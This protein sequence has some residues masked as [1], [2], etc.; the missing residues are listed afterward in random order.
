MGAY[1]QMQQIIRWA[2]VIMLASLLAGCAFMNREN[3][4]LMNQVEDN[5]WPEDTA[6]Q[7]LVFPVVF[8]I[9]FAALLVDVVVVH[10]STV[11]GDAWADTEDLLWRGM[12]WEERYVTECAAL[13]WRAILTPV[14]LTGDFL[15]RSFFDIPS[16]AE[17]EREEREEEERT[18]TL[19]ELKEEFR[20][21]GLDERLLEI[22]SLLNQSDYQEAMVSLR[23]FL[24]ELYQTH[25]RLAERDELFIS[26]KFLYEVNKHY[27]IRYLLA[28][29]RTIHGMGCYERIP[30]LDNIRFLR[31]TESMEKAEKILDD[32]W[33]SSNPEAR[34]A[35]F[36]FRMVLLV[37]PSER[38]PYI[39]EALEDPAPILR[40]SALLML[41]NS[42][43]LNKV[44]EAVEVIA[45]SDEDPINRNLAR[46][47]LG[48][49]E[50]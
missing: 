29:L 16:R 21:E 19:D 5:L 12:R 48:I 38:L 20:Q 17:Q 44:T 15:G 28:M 18:V 13:P 41:E 47:M 50:E 42:S 25:G 27:H 43:V 39:K 6:M 36:R 1:P 11:V 24:H 35:A 2:I 8:P 4:Y 14:V 22:D 40:Y 46:S 23:T 37:E 7:V 9:G 30:H 34:W 32:M 10:P 49:E 3:T 26:E 45:E 31:D 33:A